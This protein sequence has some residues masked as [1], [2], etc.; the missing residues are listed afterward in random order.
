MKKAAKTFDVAPLPSVETQ[1]K[2]DASK[3]PYGAIEIIVISV[4]M[5]I[6]AVG[7]SLI[8]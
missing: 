8:P 4:I 5:I 3:A 7:T 6:T 2:Q 1:L